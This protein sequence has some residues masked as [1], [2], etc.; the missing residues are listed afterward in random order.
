MIGSVQKGAG[1]LLMEYAIGKFTECPIYLEN[2]NIKD[3][4]LFYERHGFHSIKIID[5]LGINL[6]LLTNSKGD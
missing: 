1:R 6:D 3:N 5:V 2:S 4:Q